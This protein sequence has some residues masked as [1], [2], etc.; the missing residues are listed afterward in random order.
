[1]LQNQKKKKKKKK[2]WKFYGPIGLEYRNNPKY[3]D[4]HPEQTV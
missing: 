1:M 2:Y 3:W 4:R